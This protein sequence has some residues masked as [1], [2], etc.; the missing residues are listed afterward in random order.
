MNCE[1]LRLC[2][3][4]LGKN[5][6][7]DRGNCLGKSSKAC[8]SLKEPSGRGPPS[9]LGPY[10]GDKTER[11]GLS[12]TYKCMQ[13]SA[14]QLIDTK[15]AQCLLLK[16][17]E[18]LIQ[19]LI[20]FKVFFTNRP[21]DPTVP[22][23]C[24]SSRHFSPSLQHNMACP[25]KHAKWRYKQAGAV[26]RIFMTLKLMPPPTSEETFLECRKI[27]AFHKLKLCHHQKPLISAH[28][29]FACSSLLM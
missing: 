1:S 5:C 18:C 8:S 6:K 14:L 28:F 25:N 20:C 29:L 11:L 21:F 7:K 3:S 24:S 13:L 17:M 12:H 4:S 19:T 9:D 16:L 15:R 23:S 27:C 10:C 22:S 26:E 2:A